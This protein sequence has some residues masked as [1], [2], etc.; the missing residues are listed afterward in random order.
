MEFVATTV[1][2]QYDIK[3]HE[4]RKLAETG[5]D[6]YYSVRDFWDQNKDRDV[7]S[8]SPKQRGWLER[9]EEDIETNWRE[10]WLQDDADAANNFDPGDTF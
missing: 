5:R 7:N 6:Y 1:Q 2:N 9:I 8:L 10:Q 4:I 3:D